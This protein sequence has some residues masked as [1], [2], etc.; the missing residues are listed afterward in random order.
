MYLDGLIWFLDAISPLNLLFNLEIQVFFIFD[1][2]LTQFRGF[3]VYILL[4]YVKTLESNLVNST[5]ESALGNSTF[6]VNISELSWGVQKES[7]YYQIFKYILRSHNH[8]P[9]FWWLHTNSG[10]VVSFISFL[11][12]WIMFK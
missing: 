3:F 4:I 5:L 10:F 2:L 8:H 7:T 12:S 9:S 11:G 1:R 6:S